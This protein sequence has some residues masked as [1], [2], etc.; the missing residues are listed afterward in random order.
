MCK[1]TSL[2]RDANSRIKKKRTQYFYTLPAKEFG[3]TF[4]KLFPSRTGAETVSAEHLHNPRGQR[5]HGRNSR[6]ESPRPEETFINVMFIDA[7]YR[8][9]L[10]QFSNHEIPAALMIPSITTPWTVIDLPLLVALAEK[11]VCRQGDKI[12]G[13][14]ACECLS[15]LF[16]V[17]SRLF[18]RDGQISQKDSAREN[19]MG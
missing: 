14:P 13:S 8:G 6:H 7:T 9:A 12:L 15:L 1:D 10:N 4:Y 16:T 18:K 5:G 2:H 17:V 11:C 19:C 3:A